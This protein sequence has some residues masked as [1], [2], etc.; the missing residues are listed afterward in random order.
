MLYEKIKALG[1][2]KNLSIARIEALAGLSNGAIGKWRKSNP[3]ISNLKAVAD[4]LEVK[5]D[6]L[7]N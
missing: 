7:L 2:A 6:D 1:E 5:I 3:N 4:L